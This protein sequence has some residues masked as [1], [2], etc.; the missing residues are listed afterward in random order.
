MSTKSSA[1]FVRFGLVGVVNTAIDFGA[2]VLL[3]RLVDLAPLVAN[4]LAFVIAVTNS[5]FMNRH[6]TFRQHQRNLSLG[7]YLHF[8]AVNTGGLLMG[9]LAIILLHGMMPVEVAKI[10]AAGFTLIFNFTASKY[11]VFRRDDS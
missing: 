4:T 2:F 7:H 10:I 9:T 1:E 11:F 3:H 8:V 5:Y 6:W